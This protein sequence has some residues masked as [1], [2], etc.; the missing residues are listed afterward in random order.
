MNTPK[1]TDKYLSARDIDFMLY[2]WLDV[3]SLTSRP[4]FENHSKETFDAVLE[5]SEDIAKEYF[6][7]HARKADTNEPTFDGEHVHMIPEVA[8]ALAQFAEAG[9]TAS[10][11][12][13]ELGGIQLPNVVARACFSW[14]QSANIGTSSYPMLT[15]GNAALLLAYGTQD[16]IDRFVMP[17]LEGRFFGTMCLS[18]PEVGSSLGDVSTHAVPQADGTFRVHGQKMW[19]SAGEHE[20]SENIVHLVLAR[21][22]GDPAGAKGLSL[23]IVPKFLVNADGSLGERNDVALSG[24]NHKMGYRGTT[25]TLL[26]FGEGEHTPGGAAGA[27]GYLVGE[28]TKGLQYMFHMMNGARIGVGAGAVA[29]GYHGYLDA[30]AYARDRLQGRPVENKDPNAAPVPIVKHADVRR[31]LLASKSYV[32]GGQ[33]LILY[34]ARLLDDQQTAPTEEA[35]A[36]AALLL[37]VL[38]PIV[39]TWPSQWCLEANFQAIQVLGGAGY[40]RDHDVEQ[41]Y[42]DNRLNPIHEGTHGIQANDLLG[43]KVIMKGGA[44]LAL[45]LETVRATIAKVT[46]APAGTPAA[47]WAEQAAALEANLG[48]IEEVTSALWK[49]GDPRAALANA[50]VYL[51][52]FGHT[53]L[54]WLWLEQALAAEVAAGSRGD[55]DFLRGKRAAARYFFSH[56]L[57]RTGPQFDLLAQVETTL[58][59]L[60]DNWL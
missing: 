13:E 35:R 56:E 50:W 58:P 2:D 31:M 41:L 19:I 6:A 45:Y 36:R 29:L 17:E 47:D 27:V 20:L 54:A 49:D 60:D 34:A 8:P 24:L 59:D 18:E 32:E 38:T 3:E 48:R 40:T 44:G 12:D 1:S 10:T 53:T 57:P 33:A 43:R 26:N 51:E 9:L 28:R 7:P 55:D 4:R 42:R 11:L 46:E 37:D 25:N 5:V 15:M 22:D 39:K 52:A 21:A 16:Q 30:L 14:F 23:F